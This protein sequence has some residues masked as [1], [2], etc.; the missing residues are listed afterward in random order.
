MLHAGYSLHFVVERGGERIGIEVDGPSHFVGRKPN[1]ATLLKRRQQGSRLVSVLYWEWN[2]AQHRSDSLS[3]A[4]ER[5][6][7]SDASPKA[8]AP[9]ASLYAVRAAQSERDGPT[10]S[11]NGLLASSSSTQVRPHLRH[12]CQRLPSL[13]RSLAPPGDERAWPRCPPG[14]TCRAVMR[15]VIGVRREAVGGGR[16]RL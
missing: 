3:L 8:S 4:L 13:P 10:C 6:S 15:R 5:G 2:A 14:D 1:G 12:G 7:M 16:V 11:T 9:K